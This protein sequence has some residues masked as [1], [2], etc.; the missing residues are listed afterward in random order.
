MNKF[1]TVFF[2]SFILLIADILINKFKIKEIIVWNAIDEL[3][4][5]FNNKNIINYI[6]NNDKLI[7]NKVSHNVSDAIDK[8]KEEIGYEDPKIKSIFTETEKG[9]T[10]L[11]GKMEIKSS[12]NKNNE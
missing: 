1:K 12:W 7:S 3:A 5:K 2:D 4:R 10:L 9:E 6:I 11:G 8:V